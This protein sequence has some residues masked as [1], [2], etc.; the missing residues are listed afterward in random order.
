MTQE[1]RQWLLK[2]R[3]VGMVQEDDFELVTTPV[4]Q[5]GDGESGQD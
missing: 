4:P 2:R 5:P 1:N 3:P